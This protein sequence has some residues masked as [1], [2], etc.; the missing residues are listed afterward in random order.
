[1]AVPFANI[2]HGCNSVDGDPGGLKLADMSSPRREFGADLGAEKVLRHQVPARRVTPAAAVIVATIR[3]L[4]MHGGVAKEALGAENLP[5]L[6]PASPISRAISPIM[7]QVRRAD[8]RRRQSL[9]CGHRGRTRSSSR[10]TVSD[11]FG[12]KTD[13]VRSLGARRRRSEDLAQV[14]GRSRRCWRGQVSAPLPRCD[15]PLG[16][17]ANDRAGDLRPPTTFG[18]TCRAK[19]TSMSSIRGLGQPPDLRRQDPISFSDRSRSWGAGGHIPR[20]AIFVLRAGAGFV[21]VLM[22]D[23][24]TMPGLPRTPAAERI[25]IVDGEIEGI[26]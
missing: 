3:A 9:Q 2:A 6:R 17:D 21:V 26:S 24:R 8:G 22:G 19:E 23:I 18:W 7:R 4:K 12:V 10:P 14:G 20:S 1:M 11:K 13:R 15:E 25:R 5:A 16:E